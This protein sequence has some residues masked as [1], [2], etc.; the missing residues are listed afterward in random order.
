MQQLSC[1]SCVAVVQQQRWSPAL[2]SPSACW[3]WTDARP[4][5]SPAWAAPVWER[6]ADW[7]AGL[8]S[9]SWPAENMKSHRKSEEQRSRF[10]ALI[11]KLKRFLI[12]WYVQMNSGVYKPTFK[13]CVH[14]HDFD[15]SLVLT[16]SCKLQLFHEAW[17]HL[18]LLLLSPLYE[19][20]TSAWRRLD[21]SS[22]SVEDSSVLVWE[23]LLSSCWRRF[24]RNSQ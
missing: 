8:D 19:L 10:M 12:Y 22:S 21:S 14:H 2:W 6:C 9:S 24:V 3:S 13:W 1:R 20:C 15:T 16:I 18:L 11:Q 4:P 5:S 17:W 23:E 7:S